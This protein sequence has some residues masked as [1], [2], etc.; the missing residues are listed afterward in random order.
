MQ[1][2]AQHWWKLI[3]TTHNTIAMTF[4]GFEKI[5]LDKYFP[6]PVKQAMVQE[7]MTLKKGNL[8]V[9]QYVVRFVEL[10]RHAKTIMPTDDDK[11][12]KFEWGL[13]DTRRSVMAQSFS[14][15]S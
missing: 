8:S 5:F 10:S 9:T 12:R 7:F 11:A 13:G 15:Y 3:E 4:E 14:T 6:T 2:E 1:W